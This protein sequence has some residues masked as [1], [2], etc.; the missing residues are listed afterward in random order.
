[1][2]SRVV[3]VGVWVATSLA[4]LAGGAAGADDAELDEL[5]NTVRQRLVHTW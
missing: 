1:M 2:R 5:K 3:S 4:L